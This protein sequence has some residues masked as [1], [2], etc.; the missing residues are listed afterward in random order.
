VPVL[1]AVVGLVSGLH[2]IVTRGPTMPL[3]RVGVPCSAPAVGVVLIFS[4]NRTT[5]SHVRTGTGGRYSITL[6][7]GSYAVTLSSTP[8]IGIGMRPQTA[9]VVPGVSRRLNFSIDTGIR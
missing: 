7:P 2:G 8:R 6:A 5:V 9:R 4:R 3:C 1:L